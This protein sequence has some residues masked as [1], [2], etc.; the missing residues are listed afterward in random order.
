MRPART[1]LRR[2]SPPATVNVAPERRKIPAP[3]IAPTAAIVTS[4]RPRSLVTRTR[5]SSRTGEGDATGGERGKDYL[6]LCWRVYASGFV[7]DFTIMEPREWNT[8]STFSPV[9]ALVR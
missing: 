1:T 2:V 7:A 9:F 5:T 3:T 4:R 8:V 6:S